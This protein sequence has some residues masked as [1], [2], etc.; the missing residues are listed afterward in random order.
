VTSDGSISRVVPSI[1]AFQFSGQNA[2]ALGPNN[3]IWAAFCAGPEPPSTINCGRSR[4]ISLRGDGTI[5]V[6]KRLPAVD[7]S[8]NG[9]LVSSLTLGPD[10]ALYAAAYLSAACPP[11]VPTHVVFRIDGAGNVTQ[12]FTVP[13]AT[14]IA[15]GP[16]KN[17][18]V[19]QSLSTNKIARLTT[20]G[21]ITEFDVPT[22]NAGPNVITAGND[23]AMWF[24]EFHAGKIG[25]ITMSGAITE[26]PTPTKDSHP[27]GI[28]SLPG[29]FSNGHGRIWFAE[30]YTDRIGKIEF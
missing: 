30:Q 25:R 27:A 9:Y 24:T 22:P 6:D 3:E 12:T 26:F 1:G 14:F 19:T 16:D 4:L 21:S 28:A 20:T 13:D 23:G 17:L 5:D 11:G 2:I 15:T 8:G 7:N 10:G 29:E 18:W